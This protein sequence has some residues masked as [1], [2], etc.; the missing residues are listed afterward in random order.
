[1]SLIRQVWL[2]VLGIIV[3]A[4]VGSVM[5]SVWTARSYLETQLAL[6][7]NDN[8]QALALTLT[9]Q[10]GDRALIELVLA[11]QF[12]TGFYESIRWLSTDGKVLAE[13][14]GNMADPGAPEWFVRLVPIQ[15][16]PGIAQISSGWKAIG[17]VEVISQTSFAYGDLWAGTLRITSSLILMGLV[18]AAIGHLAVRRLSGRLD[19]VVE[20]AEAL[21]ER[22]F[23]SVKE[24]A[25][26]ELR[27]VT[28]AM[29]GM[30][31]RVRDMFGE[32]AQ[33]VE[34][35]RREANCDSLTGVSHR[36]HF[37]SQVESMLQRDDSV[38]QGWLVLVRFVRLAEVNRTFGHA[39]TDALLRRL[40]RSLEL[41]L[42]GSDAPIAVGRLNGADFAVLLG[43][44][45][46]AQA[47]FREI[48]HRLHVA[49]SG[50]VDVAVVASAVAW[51]RGDT[52]PQLLAS[53]DAALARAE[54]RG[55]F[56]F[57]VQTSPGSEVRAG[58]EEAWRRG[59]T[60]ALT[61][62]RTRLE[63]FPL[64]DPEGRLV[65]CECP[66]RLQFTPGGAYESASFWL[67]YAIRTRMTAAVDE[68]ALDLAM[69]AIITDA[70][71]RGVNMAVASLLDPGL[72]ARLRQRLIRVP[73]AAQRLSIDI[74]EAGAATQAAAL[75]EMSRQLRP[76]GVRIGLEHA[77]ERIPSLG[78]VLESGLDYVKLARSFVAGVSSDASRAALVR[79]TTSMLH[80]IGLRVYAEGIENSA[81]LD[82]LWACGLDGATGP[83][84]HAGSS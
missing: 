18:A 43:H 44:P 67:P 12:D 26:P 42:H 73:Q 51:M 13:Q 10:R 35:L 82:V 2:L 47:D 17:R 79:G 76:L 77:G 66:L 15:S 3:A 56:S 20:Q 28:Q 23:I 29:N 9:Q 61:E 84:V 7:N 45:S 83:A 53:A 68:E 19:A 71:P 33:Q 49:L 64:V 30:V 80:G 34:Q 59:L 65:H 14:H 55:D 50:G 5:A 54:A 78:A 72:T 4:C 74:D 27:R 57:D 8:A 81:D 70:Q 1:M 25:T 48:L 22:R 60:A 52:V 36:K 24:P 58:G 41:P 63:E 16:P 75:I 38:G 21:T 40:A 39:R 11:A 31:E 37:L 62:Q 6:K 46:D 32:Q 69:S